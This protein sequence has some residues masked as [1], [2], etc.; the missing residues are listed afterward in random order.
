MYT[1]TLFFSN[2][3][4]LAAGDEYNRQQKCGEGSPPAEGEYGEGVCLKCLREYEDYG[5]FT[6]Q[7]CERCFAESQFSVALSC[8]Q[9]YSATK[10][11]W[12]RD[13][14]LGWMIEGIIPDIANKAELLSAEPTIAHGRRAFVD[15]DADG[16][17]DWDTHH[18]CNCDRCERDV[19]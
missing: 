6:H 13:Q 4:I 5:A 7:S 15:A 2:L 10:A 12:T 1:P 18:S 8:A 17:L 11:G 16:P 9:E 19:P 3:C 14:V